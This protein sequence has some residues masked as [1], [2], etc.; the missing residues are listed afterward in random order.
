MSNYGSSSSNLHSRP[1]PSPPTGV[2][3]SKRVHYTGPFAPSPFELLYLVNTGEHDD[4]LRLG[5]AAS[6]IHRITIDGLICLQEQRAALDRIVQETNTYSANLAYNA[7]AGAAGGLVLQGPIMVPSPPA[8][9]YNDNPR[10]APD[11]VGSLPK[12]I[13][14]ANPNSPEFWMAHAAYAK[15]IRNTAQLACEQF[16]RI[17]SIPTPS[18]GL[19]RPF[20]RTRP[21]NPVHPNERLAST[22]SSSTS[23]VYPEPPSP[24]SNDDSSDNGSIVV[25]HIPPSEPGSPPMYAASI[26]IRT[27]SPSDSGAKAI[28]SNMESIYS[29]GV[30]GC[31]N[32]DP[33]ATVPFRADGVLNPY[34]Q[35]LQITYADNRHTPELIAREPE[36]N[37]SPSQNA[38]PRSNNSVSVG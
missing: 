22:P 25:K 29:P 16:E 7:T 38:D 37:S 5:M 23:L 31:N 21:N 20:D 27:P 1:L 11:T 30:Q 12:N 14:N 28:Q 4:A 36:T 35:P 8:Y 2:E 24:S 34:F 9:S 10:N 19:S 6:P 13:C 18:F 32:C 15:R 33:P 3:D 17:P 26:G